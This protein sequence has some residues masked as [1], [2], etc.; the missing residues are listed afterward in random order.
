[1]PTEKKV[2][3]QELEVTFGGYSCAGEKAENQD[4]FA[5]LN[6]Q[7]QDKVHKGI[8]ACIADGCSSAKN[9]KEAATI[10]ATHTISDYLNTSASWSVKKSMAK[11]VSSLNQWFYSQARYQDQY[12]HRQ[13]DWMTTFSALILKSTTGYV[14]HIGD[15]RIGLLRDNQLMPLTRDH[16]AN[17]FLTKALGTELHQEVDF[18]TQALQQNDVFVMTCDGVHDYLSTKQIVS[19]INDTSDCLETAARKVCEAAAAHKSPDNLTCLLVKVSQLPQKCLEEIYQELTYRKVPLALRAGQKIDDYTVIRQ[20]HASVRS[21][22]YL[23]QKNESSAPV[24]LK[25]PS[26]NF[27]DDIHYLQGFMREGWAG[28]TIT[29]PNVMKVVDTAAQSRFLYHICQYMDGQTLREWLHDVKQPSIAQ[30]RSIIE[31]IVAALRAFQRLDMVHRDLKPDNVMID[32]HGKITLIDYG[33]VSIAGFAEDIHHLEDECAQGTIG[34]TAPETILSLHADFKSDLFSLGVIAYELLSG[35]LPFKP[36]PTGQIKDYTPW[37]Y[38]SIRQH[39]TDIPYWLDQALM[40][41]TAPIPKHRYDAFSEFVSDIN[42]A[43]TQIDVPKYTT[44][45]YQRNEVRIWQAMSIFF[46]LMLMVS[47]IVV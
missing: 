41:A 40:K 9:A 25:A 32:A 42:S 8:I 12:G 46:A 43:N 15:T 39:R 36:L 34:Y 2:N 10:A 27:Q 30:V 28:Q 29:H 3:K 11:V 7:G 47:L 35:K 20:I 45:F 18:Y 26:L 14:F 37:Q 44:S 31:Q 6:S 5:L 13:T 17:H 23:V 4:A 21:H 22:L 16:K 38:I 24:V 19:L 1:M 33:T